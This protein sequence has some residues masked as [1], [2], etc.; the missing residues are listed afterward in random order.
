[1]TCHS[2]IGCTN[3]RVNFGVSIV[4][5]Y[6]LDSDPIGDEFR[7]QPPNTPNGGFFINKK[8]SYG[9]F[10]DGA[11]NT[12]CASEHVKG[13]FSNGV[14][15]PKPTHMRRALSHGFRDAAMAHCV[16][17]TPILRLR[18]DSAAG[19]W[20]IG[21]PTAPDSGSRCR[22][23]TLLSLYCVRALLRAISRNFARSPLRPA[24][25]TRRA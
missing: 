10:P 15:T 25:V 23:D 16:G 6:G 3:Y 24:A 11:S 12:A 1:M 18:L 14:S 17:V 13:D 8:Y 19:P 4:E 20:M 7:H 2:A 5:G 22:S 9:D 21:A